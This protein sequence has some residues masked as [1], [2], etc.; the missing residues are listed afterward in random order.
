MRVLELRCNSADL[1]SNA[2]AHKAAPQQQQKTWQWLAAGLATT[3][4]I[5]VAI[6]VVSYRS[7]NQL[8][9]TSNAANHSYRLCCKNRGGGRLSKF[10]TEIKNPSLNLHQF[11]IPFQMV[12]LFAGNHPPLRAVV[13]PL[14]HQLSPDGRD[15]VPAGDRG[16]S[17]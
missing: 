7:L 5:L 10:P 6:G 11:Q 16:R 15:D 12:S 14:S 2:V 17:Q 1:K 8:F 13:L 9:T 4:T 3:S